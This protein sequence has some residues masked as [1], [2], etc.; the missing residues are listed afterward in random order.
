DDARV[1]D[2]GL[3][4]E[5]GLRDLRT[6]PAAEAVQV[7]VGMGARE[8][9]PGGDAPGLDGAA[10]QLVSQRDRRVLAALLVAQADLLPLAVVHQRQ[11]D[12]AGESALAEFDRRAGIQQ[13]DVAEE[14]RAV[15]GGVVAHGCPGRHSTSTAWRCCGTNSPMARRSRPSSAATARN[16]ASPSGATATSRPPLVCG[17]HSRL[18]RSWPMGAMRSP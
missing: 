14:Q 12:R 6:Q 15:I 7:T 16:S 1:G 13:R 17:S 4:L 18:M 3:V 9:G 10:D 8:I 11:V 2:A 5:P